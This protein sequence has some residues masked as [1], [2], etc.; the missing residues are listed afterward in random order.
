MIPRDQTMILDLLRQREQEFVR[1]WEC[2]KLIL[3]ILGQPYPFPS[4]P[5][6]PSLRRQPPTKAGGG[7]SPVGSVTPGVPRLRRLQKG[8]E[9]AY[10][11][12]CRCDDRTVISLQVDTEFLMRLLDVREPEFNVVKVEAGLLLPDGAFEVTE[13]LWGGPRP[14]GPGSLERCL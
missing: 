2:E 12:H 10:R 5:P 11:V 9:N 6:L 8:R 4:P 14:G 13:M 7:A 1:V 3:A